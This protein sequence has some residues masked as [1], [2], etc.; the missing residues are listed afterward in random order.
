MPG[1][2]LEAVASVFSHAPTGTPPF[3]LLSLF[4]PCTPLP[5]LKAT[6][7]S[8][9]TLGFSVP[10]KSSHEW[11]AYLLFCE[12]GLFPVIFFSLEL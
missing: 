10:M 11:Q 6:R 1:A 7:D 5:L 4:L 8:P 3:Q 2:A 9:G 12:M